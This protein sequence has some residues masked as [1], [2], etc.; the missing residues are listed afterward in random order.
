ML[1]K[2]ASNGKNSVIELDG[3][4]LGGVTAIKFEHTRDSADNNRCRVNVEFD[5]TAA[6]NDEAAN[7]HAFMDGCAP[8]SDVLKNMEDYYGELLGNAGAD[9]APEDNKT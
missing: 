3:R 2:L 9:K 4:R 1:L 8:F 6:T 5:L 7:K